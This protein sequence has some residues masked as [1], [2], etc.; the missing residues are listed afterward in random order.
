LTKNNLATEDTLRYLYLDIPEEPFTAP[1]AGENICI[2]PNAVG[3]ESSGM[4]AGGHRG[5]NNIAQLKDFPD[6]TLPA[7]PALL[8]LALQLRFPTEN[9]DSIMTWG[10]FHIEKPQRIWDYKI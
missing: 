8:Q 4:E 10:I 3:L 7:N 2:S 9:N 5:S 1:V 6:N